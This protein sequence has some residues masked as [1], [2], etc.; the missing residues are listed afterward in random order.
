MGDLDLAAAELLEAC[1]YIYSDG[2][3]VADEATFVDGTELLEGLPHATPVPGLPSSHGDDGQGIDIDCFPFVGQ[4]DL[5][6]SSHAKERDACCE[7]FSAYE[8]LGGDVTEGSS[9][10]V[11]YHFIPQQLVQKQGFSDVYV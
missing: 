10:S 9:E 1:D 2:N 5:G 11:A 4:G 8:L 6:H 3:S 7:G